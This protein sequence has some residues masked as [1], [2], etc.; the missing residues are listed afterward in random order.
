MT[1]NH[2]DNTRNIAILGSTGSIGTQT[3]DVISEY[4]GRFRATVLTATQMWKCW[5]LR[6]ASTCP[7]R[8]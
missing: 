2:H 5:P 6:H 1:N 7:G 4:P 3:L 8:L